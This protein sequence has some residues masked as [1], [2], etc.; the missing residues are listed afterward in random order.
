MSSSFVR[1]VAYGI[2]DLLT[3]KKGIARNINGMKIRF[4]P[5]WSRYFPSDYESDNYE[6]LKVKLKEGMQ[7]IDIGAHIG[8]FSVYTSQLTGPTGK[9]ICFEPTPDT[10]AI[11]K[12]T[13]R[14]NHCKNIIPKQ[15]AVGA[16][17]GTATFYIS[18]TFEGCNANSL[19]LNKKEANGYDVTITTLDTICHDHDI[20]PDLVKIDAEG[21]EL[22]VLKGG[23]QT[24]TTT[25]PLVILGLHPS[26]IQTKGDS[27]KEIWDLI[28]SYGYKVIYEGATI[29]ENNFISQPHLFDVH[30]VPSTT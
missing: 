18:N 28:K 22:D 10:F 30:L 7:V 4:T 13:I 11:L 14:L 2:L 16:S 21:A 9:V 23:K 24:L 3:F 27:L 5:K 20:R 19:V 29:T 25:K 26:F 1:N 12:E 6:F 8:L 15:E 17:C